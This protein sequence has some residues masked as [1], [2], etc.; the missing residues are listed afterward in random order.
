MEKGR[1]SRGVWQI[2]RSLL[3]QMEEAVE[4]PIHH[5][6]KL[7]SIEGIVDPFPDF[8]KIHIVPGILE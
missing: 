1:K 2:R 3:Q 5:L 4:I 6:N 8:H 7:G